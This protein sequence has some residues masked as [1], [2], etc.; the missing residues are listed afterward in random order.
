MREEI[1]AA[2]DRLLFEVGDEGKVSVGEIC[3]AVG[4]TPPSLYHHF[5]DKEAL[6]REV[7]SRRFERF[8]AELDT[9]AERTEDPLE[10][11]RRKGRAYLGWAIENPEHYRVLFMGRPGGAAEG[12]MRDEPGAGLRELIGDVRDCME[13]GSFAAGDPT[14]VAVVM[15]SAVH[16]IAALWV[17]NAGIPRPLAERWLEISADALY[18]GLAPRKRRPRP[19]S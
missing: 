1:L 19:N 18:R 11:L 8:A 7:C 5:A 15:W 10:R 4:C 3:R 9:A 6:L 16:G 2:T 13:A 12:E 14:E 17:S